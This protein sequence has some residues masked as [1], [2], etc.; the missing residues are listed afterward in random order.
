MKADFSYGLLHAERLTRMLVDVEIA[1][2][3][4]KQA[5]LHPERRVLAERYARRMM[6]R[7]RHMADEIR[8]GDTSVLDWIDELAQTQVSPEAETRVS[9]KRVA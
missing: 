8:G 4:A 5:Q 7:I 9:E 1:T 6:P 2:I 3:L